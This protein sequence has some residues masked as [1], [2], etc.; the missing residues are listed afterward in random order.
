MLA[1]IL[2]T[3]IIIAALASSI[4]AEKNGGLISEHR[5]NNRSNDASGARDEHFG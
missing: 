1:A 5:Y 4:R 2:I 3:L